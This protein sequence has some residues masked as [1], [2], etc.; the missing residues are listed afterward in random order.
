M[1][2]IINNIII[3]H[4]KL[5]MCFLVNFKKKDFYAAFGKLYN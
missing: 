1:C 4:K 3:S 2:N 5:N